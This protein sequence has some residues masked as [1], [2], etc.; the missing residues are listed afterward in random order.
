M[1]D[2]SIYALF[3]LER[4]AAP[5][6]ILAQ[7]KKRSAE[8]DI[9]SVRARLSSKLPPN[10]ASLVSE[11]VFMDGNEYLKTAA[12]ILLDPSSRQCYDAWLDA[13]QC[14]SPEKMKLTRSRLLWFNQMTNNVTFGENMIRSLE[15]VSMK[16]D[17]AKESVE[18]E[19]SPTNTV[20][21]SSPTCRG[22]HEP[23]SF[24]HDYLVLHCHCT[25]R[26]G[27]VKCLENF[28]EKVNHKC[29]VCRQRL[30]KRHQVSK[31]LFWNV[32]EKYKFI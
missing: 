15:C 8:W 10:R 13:I 18:V 4:S 22:C 1:T 23:F 20:V 16:K 3:N 11:R 5:L 19:S 17:V 31:Y 14:Q 7:C 24:S 32:K 9:S 6:E 2:H 29:P 30:L 27:H 12:A 25:T 21:L 28:S 26:V